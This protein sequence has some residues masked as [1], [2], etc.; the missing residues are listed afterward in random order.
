MG[1]QSIDDFINET[2]TNGKTAKAYFQ[3]TSNN[4]AA[5]SAGRWHDTLQWAGLPGAMTLTGTAGTAFQLSSSTAG[6]LPLGG[7]NVSPDTRHLVKQWITSPTAT[8]VPATLI[9][10]DFLVCYPSLV[11]TGTATTLTPA[12][13]PRYTD[14]AGVMGVVTT[15][16]ALGAASPALTFTYTNQAGT[17]SRVAAAHTAPG[18]SAPLSTNFLTD[19]SPFIRLAA[20]DTGIRS[21]QS[22]TLASGT[23][24]TVSLLL[25]R[26]LEEIPLLAINT[27]SMMDYVFQ[28]PSLPQIQDGA[29]LGYLVQVG[30][31][32]ITGGIIQGSV[33]TG[34]G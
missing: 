10:C 23:T 2:T 5:S 21:V 33:Q 8:A 22:Y 31:A 12:A 25:C 29:C 24:G 17:G 1:F 11:V 19:G 20:G 32:L 9:L 27:A 16:A 14:G 13:L 3:K 28:S 18:N 15:V 34:W 30:G 7:G 26:P 6:S 4:G